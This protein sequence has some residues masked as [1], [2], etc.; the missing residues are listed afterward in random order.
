MRIYN[1]L[2]RTKEEFIPLDKGRVRMYACGITVYDD[3]HIG[4]ARQAIIFD[5]ISRYLRFSGYDVTYVRNYTDVE[6]KI[7]ARYLKIS[8]VT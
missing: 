4:H 1:A 3:C 5:T 6:D 8:N 7:I 2:S